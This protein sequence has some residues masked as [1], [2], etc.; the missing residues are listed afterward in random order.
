MRIII[1]SLLGLFVWVQAVAQTAPV[2]YGYRSARYDTTNHTW[3]ADSSYT[4]IP[5]ARPS[6]ST[7]SAT[8]GYLTGDSTYKALH[9]T[10][11]QARD[12]LFRYYNSFQTRWYSFGKK[13]YRYDSAGRIVL[14][15]DISGTFGGSTNGNRSLYAYDSQGRMVSLQGWYLNGTAWYPSY[16]NSY[17]YCVVATL[18]DTL[19][20]STAGPGAIPLSRE[21][22]YQDGSNPRRD[23]LVYYETYNTVLQSWLPN[24]RRFTHYTD[25]TSTRSWFEISDGSSYVPSSDEIVLHRDTLSLRVALSY[26]TSR[27]QWDTVSMSA[28]LY[29]SAHNPHFWVDYRYDASLRRWVYGNFEKATYQYRQGVVARQYSYHPS[30]NVIL[31]K[32][33]YLFEAPTALPRRALPTL[34][35]YPNPATDQV[36]IP[37]PPSLRGSIATLSDGVGRVCAQVIVQGSE[38]VFDLQGLPPGLY[39]A[40]FSGPT[41]LHHVPVLKQ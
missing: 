32:V 27:L 37:L 36:R 30:S 15:D 14:K 8:I 13:R 25:S 41:G 7:W 24:S 12:T 23:T 34:L 28:V 33:D 26:N 22:H 16:I 40:S 35:A 18:P 11:D 17:R 5:P 31:G 20:T 6:T 21:F 19:I 2:T 38:A 39:Q 1:V 4:I 10:D 3:Y 29:D 9:A